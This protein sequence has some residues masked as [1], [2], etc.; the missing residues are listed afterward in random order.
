MDKPEVLMVGGGPD[1]YIER[2]ARAFNLQRVP[3]PDPAAIDPAVAQRVRAV[4]AAAP[5]PAAMIAAL[6]RLE[7]ICNAGAGYE[8]IDVAAARA[9][10]IVVTNTPGVTDGCV[11]DMAM[12]LLLAA[13][14]HIVRG[15]KYARSGAWSKAAYPLVPR[16]FGKRMGILGLGSIGLAIAR[17]ALAFDMTVSYH[18]RRPRPDVPYA[19]RASPAALAAESDFFVVACP[20]GP[21]TRH[22]VD[23]AVLKTLGPKGYVVNIS[24]GSVIDEEALI[25]A[26]ENGTIAGAGLDVLEHEP[27]VP[28]RLAALDN[29]V[30]MP[31]RGGGTIETWE[32]VTEAIKANLNAF[33]AGKKPLTPIPE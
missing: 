13:A 26:L 9:R 5:M 8:K 19:Y 25:A 4:I 18:N 29:V 28:A 17:R 11:A 27:A 3:K 21:A 23:A 10:G 14:R 12:G 33:F 32:E 30:I 2:Y 22:I 6:P 16:V 20:G 15:D 24:R 7:I 31:H 1:W